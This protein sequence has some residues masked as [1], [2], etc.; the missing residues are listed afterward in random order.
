MKIYEISRHGVFCKARIQAYDIEKALSE[1]IL[2]CTFKTREEA[3]N[4]IK[5]IKEIKRK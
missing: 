5:S 2:F 3:I 4:G 1:Y